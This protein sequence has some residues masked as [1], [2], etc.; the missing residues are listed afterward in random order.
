MDER[1]KRLN[2]AAERLRAL[3]SDLGPASEPELTEALGDSPSEDDK[4]T[5]TP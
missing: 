4:R 1:R 2:E 5:L 3:Q